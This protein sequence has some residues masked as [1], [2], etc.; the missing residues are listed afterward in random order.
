VGGVTN[1][2]GEGFGFDRWR[3]DIKTWLPS[4]QISVYPHTVRASIE[5][6]GDPALCISDVLIGPFNL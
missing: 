6:C 1:D 5:I 2:G 4:L 3:D